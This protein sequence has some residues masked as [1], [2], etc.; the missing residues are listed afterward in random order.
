M[1]TGCFSIPERIFDKNGGGAEKV[2]RA[3]LSIDLKPGFLSR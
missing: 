1:K 2:L 3:R